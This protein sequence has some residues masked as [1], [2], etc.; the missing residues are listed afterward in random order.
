MDKFVAEMTIA[1]AIPLSKN[2]I[3]REPGSTMTA[4]KKARVAN[5]RRAN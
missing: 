1:A 3:R 2:Q 4:M 5:A